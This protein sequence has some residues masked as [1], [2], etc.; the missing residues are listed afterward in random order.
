MADVSGFSIFSVPFL[1]T[2]HLHCHRTSLNNM[3]NND[4]MH[5]ANNND[6]IF[7]SDYSKHDLSTSGAFGRKL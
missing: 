5:T 4:Y 7:C 6:K 3:M 2:R 1:N